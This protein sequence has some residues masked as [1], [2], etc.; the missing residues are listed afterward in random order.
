MFSPHLRSAFRRAF[1]HRTPVPQSIRK[2]SCSRAVQNDIIAPEQTT[3]SRYNVLSPNS[4][5]AGRLITSIQKFGF[6]LGSDMSLRGPLLILNHS[7]F[8]W[9]VPQYGVG[10]NEPVEGG[11]GLWDEPSSVF[12]GW[13]LEPFKALEIVKPRP[14]IL[15]IGTGAQAQ[16]LPP[17]IR[18]HILGLGIQ[19]EVLNTRYAASTY[20]VLLQEGR[21]V[22]AALL[23]LIPTSARTGKQ[24][25]ELLTVK[26]DQ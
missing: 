7:V 2:I 14:E 16:Q 5:D 24:L 6:A 4:S 18:S 22:S 20:N 1:G 9:D 12:H 13:D 3:L 26:P 21:R 23:P 10:S 17:F 8:L 19:L 15:V 11:N 25:V